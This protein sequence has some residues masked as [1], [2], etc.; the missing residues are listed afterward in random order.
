M[1]NTLIRQLEDLRK[2]T[3]EQAKAL[4]DH[5]ASEKR[6]LTGDENRQWEKMNED[7]DGIDARLSMLKADNQREA[8]TAATFAALGITGGT[9]GESEAGRALREAVLNRSLA[10]VELTWAAPAS[11]ANTRA[12]VTTNNVGVTVYGQLVRH[13]VESSAVLSAGATLL[14]TDSGEPLKIPK[15]TAMSTASITTE[16]A[17]IGSSDPGLGS[18]ELK[19]YKYSFLTS[20]TRELAE[21]VTFDLEGY[22]AAQVGDALGNGFGTDLVAGDGTAKPTG[23]LSSATSGVTGGAGVVGAFTAD[24]LIDLYHS[25][26]SPYARSSSA[27]WLMRNS[28]LA[29]V[30]KLKD[31]QGRYLFDVNIPTG[32]PGAAGQ[33]LGRPVF[34]DPNV[35]AVAL[36]AKSVLF[37]DMS[38]VWVRHVNGV[39]FERSLDHGFDT[40]LVWFKAVLRA[41]GALVDTTG[42]LKAFVGNAA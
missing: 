12:L 19:A 34:V 40:D 26:A 32:Y 23:I 39:R 38:K 28:T 15:T 13:M 16:G 11:G 20:I 31:T 22:I 35:P 24:N 14:T 3:W 18:V 4:L 41:D 27:A 29:A 21:D 8:D 1:S 9:R 17:P 2:R 37:G 42:A 25:V 10:P 7:L 6:D 30:R 5:A 36:G 33:L